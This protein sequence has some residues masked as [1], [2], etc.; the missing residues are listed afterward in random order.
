MDVSVFEMENVVQLAK[1]KFLPGK[2]HLGVKFVPGE[3]THEN[4]LAEMQ[5]KTSEEEPIV[6]INL[7]RNAEYVIV[8]KKLSTVLRTN[9]MQVTSS[10]RHFQMS[11]CSQHLPC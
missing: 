11:I 6:I 10:R 2:E 9:A 1:E 5:K 3:I 4:L 7:Q 8:E